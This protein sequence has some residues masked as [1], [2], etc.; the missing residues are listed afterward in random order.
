MIFVIAAI[1][2]SCENPP[3]QFIQTPAPVPDST[4]KFESVIPQPYSVDST[5]GS[6]F[7]LKQGSVIYVDAGNNELMNIGQ[8]LAG[9]LN[10]S[11]G[12]NIQVINASG[13][14]GKGNIYL[15]TAGADVSLGNEGYT[16]KITADS[17]VLSAIMP[18]GIFRGV[19]TLRQLFPAEIES[20]V[21]VHQLWGIG[22]GTIKDHPLYPWRGAML[23]VARHFFSVKD[24]EHFIDLIAYYKINRLHIHLTDDQGWRIF[25]NSWPNL[26]TYGGST[27][28][29]GGMGGYYS[30]ADYSKI[31][32]YA[33]GRYITVVPEIDMP[34]HTNAALASYAIL[35]SDGVTPPLYTGINVGF[36][37]LDTHKEITYQF[38]D[39]VIREIS[40]L[41]PGQYIHIG[42]D[43]ASTITQSDYIKF[44]DSVQIIVQDYGKQMV[45]WEEIGQAN[46]LT[47]S[48]A[49]HWGSNLAHNASSQGAK[50]IMSPADKT[51]MDMKYNASTVLGQN[52]AGY[53]EVQDAYSWDPTTE[54]PGVTARNIIGIEAPLWTETIQTFSDI[55]Y[56]TFPRLCCYAEIG[57]TLAANRN[58]ND[59]KNRMA[60]N[61]KRLKIMGVNYY[62][63]PQI[64]WK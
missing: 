2:F 31:V 8:Y 36:S 19:Q 7:N 33:Q 47:S 50:I 4:F 17:V 32:S 41:T 43:E 28:V 58:W 38:I 29:G 10:P 42:G 48:I 44:I 18:E 14:P 35:D 53:I 57:W 21:Y 63:S 49:Q 25:I 51:Y 15:T 6:S 30:Q 12:F 62:Q 23:D 9:I 56:M 1:S 37:A 40:A 64:P 46:L 5:G 45:G 39:D 13:S 20:S 55:E 27:E 22:S 26:A 34:G 16:L 61:G 59:F 60:E 54:V 24:V 52:W 11:T 3:T